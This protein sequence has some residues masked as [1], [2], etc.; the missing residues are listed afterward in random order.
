MWKRSAESGACKEQRQPGWRGSQLMVAVELVNVGK[1]QKAP[2][3]P[4]Q[5]LAALGSSNLRR[6]SDMTLKML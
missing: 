6:S 1:P 2:S 4:P 3:K 5:S